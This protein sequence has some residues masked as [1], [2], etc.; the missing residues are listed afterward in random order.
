MDPGNIRYQREPEK[1][2]IFTKLVVVLFGSL[3]FTIAILILA[4][5]IVVLFKGLMF[6][7]NN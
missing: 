7:V 4:V 5:A 1:T 3:I 6:F 2:P